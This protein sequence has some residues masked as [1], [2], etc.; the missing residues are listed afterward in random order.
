[1]PTL[2]CFKCGIVSHGKFQCKSKTR[3]AALAVS[4]S[5][6]AMWKDEGMNSGHRRKVASD[7]SCLS[8]EGEGELEVA[9]R[10]ILQF[11]MILWLPNV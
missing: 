7:L 6:D 5:E 11:R 10:R 4:R 1:M 2:T 9:P 3:S 8:L